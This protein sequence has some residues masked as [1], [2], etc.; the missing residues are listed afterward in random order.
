[1]HALG[2][3]KALLLRGAIMLIGNSICLKIWCKSSC[4]PA[5]RNLAVL[6]SVGRYGR[7]C[8]NCRL[9]LLML[10][11]CLPTLRACYD[12]L[13]SHAVS[14]DCVHLQDPHPTVVWKAEDSRVAPCIQ[15][16]SMRQDRLGNGPGQRSRLSIG[17]ASTERPAVTALDAGLPW[18]RESIRLSRL[19]T[20]LSSWNRRSSTGCR[21]PRTCA[22][23]VLP[24]RPSAV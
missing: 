22:S 14:E 9:Q 4:V 10:L 16:L 11:Q 5:F 18:K 7:S 24:L 17:C 6:S 2:T 20:G 1:M 8:A 21:I 3:M 13:P 19:S 15:R 23:I 12:V